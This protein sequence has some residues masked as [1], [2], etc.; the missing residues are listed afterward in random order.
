MTISIPSSTCNGGDSGQF[1]RTSVCQIQFPDVRKSGFAWR[2][3]FHCYVIWM[4]HSSREFF[5]DCP[6]SGGLKPT[7]FSR[8]IKFSVSCYLMNY[9]IKMKS[10]IMNV[11]TSFRHA[12]HSAA[13]VSCRLLQFH[14]SHYCYLLMCSSQWPCKHALLSDFFPYPSIYIGKRDS[15]YCRTC[16]GKAAFNQSILTM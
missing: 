14:I 1:Q 7:L 3:L 4:K 5:S 12:N 8:K 16:Y 15:S 11:D 6:I 9:Y 13:F 10:N 2:N